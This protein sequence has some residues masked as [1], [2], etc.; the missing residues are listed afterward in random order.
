MYFYCKCTI[1]SLCMFQL[2]LFMRNKVS[3]FIWVSLLSST[4]LVSVIINTCV[5]CL[6]ASLPQ[7]ACYVCSIT[8]S[9]T[10]LPALQLR[11]TNLPFSLLPASRRISSTAPAPA[12]QSGLAG[13]Y[14]GDR[15][16]LED[17]AWIWW[18]VS[19][20]SS[21]LVV[22]GQV[23]WHTVKFG[24]INEVFCGG[25][26]WN[27]VWLMWLVLVAV[28]GGCWKIELKFGGKTKDYVARESQM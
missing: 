1:F 19:S 18:P 7:G 28:A 24:G 26:Q 2:P 13:S 14:T 25:S 23:W 22:Y 16:S 5:Y 4:Y 21:R 11:Q 8:I 27:F 12:T 17:N 15:G 20:T 10:R 6:N 9:S 3:N